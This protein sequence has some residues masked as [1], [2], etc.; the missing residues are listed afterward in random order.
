[1][2]GGGGGSIQDMINT[3]KRNKGMLRGWNHFRNVKVNGVYA[4]N[5]KLHRGKFTKEQTKET[6]V[7]YRRIHRKTIRKRMYVLSICVLVLLS[8]L[9]IFNERLIF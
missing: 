2:P 9:Y 3:L 6:I 7:R 5:R 4:P 1:M 8:L